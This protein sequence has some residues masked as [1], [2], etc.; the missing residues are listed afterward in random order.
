[1][2]LF[3]EAAP[4]FETLSWLFVG[5]VALHNLGEAVWL[6]AWSRTVARW[7]TPISEFAFRFA[8][9]VLTLLAAGAAWLALAQGP[10][11][12]GAYIVSGYALA[13]LINVIL[14]HVAATVALRSY[15]PGTATA[16]IL[17]APVT[18]LLI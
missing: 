17:I 10:E 15:A 5:A 3:L 7:H 4:K 14:P 16:L 2:T 8:V 9:A 11:S 18:I 1:M 6:S 13:M 12:L